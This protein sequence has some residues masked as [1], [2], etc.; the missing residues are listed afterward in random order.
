MVSRILKIITKKP[1]KLW[2]VKGMEKWRCEK[3]RIEWYF[4]KRQNASNVL[5]NGEQPFSAWGANETKI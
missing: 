5:E 2:N 1:Y 3:C 4:A